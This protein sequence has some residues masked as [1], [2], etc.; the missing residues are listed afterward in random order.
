MPSLSARAVSRECVAL[1]AALALVLAGLAAGARP[2][3][4]PAASGIGLAAAP[5]C[6]PSGLP[7]GDGPA[8]PAD[9]QHCTL[10]KA[11][12]L[13]VPASGMPRPPAHSRVAAARMPPAVAPAR[14]AAFEARAPP[15]S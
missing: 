6:A 1:L 2:V 7:P 13:V 10:C 14:S 9:C 8:A 3:A 15:L 11:F 12:A 4:G 5:V